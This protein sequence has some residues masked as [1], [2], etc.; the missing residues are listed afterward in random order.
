M[1]R[2]VWGILVL[3]LLSLVLGVG[4]GEFFFGIWLKTVPPA[5]TTNFNTGSAH[6]AFLGS[7]AVVGVVFFLWGLLSP[8]IAMM[9]RPKKT[10]PARP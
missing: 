1:S 6:A 5:M 7:G 4:A 9:F 3:M 2:R 8:V 10:E